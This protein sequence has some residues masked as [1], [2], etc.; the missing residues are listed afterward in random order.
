MCTLCIDESKARN[1]TQRI[2]S[3]W[4][5]LSTYS[6]YVCGYLKKR[7]LWEFMGFGYVSIGV[8]VEDLWV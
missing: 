7:G 4:A 3:K 2:F 6:V 5:H 8:G 1:T